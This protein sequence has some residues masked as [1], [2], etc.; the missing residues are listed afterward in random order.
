MRENRPVKRLSMRAMQHLGLVSE[1]HMRDLI[2]PLLGDR[3]YLTIYV[4][5][6]VDI[7]ICNKT[8]NAILSMKTL[9]GCWL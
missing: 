6:N 4:V 9:I 1:R 8:L 5:D 3:D 2:V 7:I